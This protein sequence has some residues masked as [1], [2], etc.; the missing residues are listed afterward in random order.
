MRYLELL[1]VALIAVIPL[2]NDLKDKRE[3][4]PFFKRITFSGWSVITFSA[5]L[6]IL[7]ALRI[8][9]EIIM[10][11]T[12]QENDISSVIEISSLSKKTIDSIYKIL[13]GEIFLRGASI[14]DNS[15]DINYEKENPRSTGKGIDRNILVLSSNRIELQN[16]FLLHS[17]EVDDINGKAF[18]YK[19]PE[20]ENL[21]CM[22]NID[23][24]FSIKI[25]NGTFADYL[26]CNKFSQIK[27]DG[28]KAK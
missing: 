6:L 1:L 27:I 5:I 13:P 10:E 12:V 20:I 2:F 9:R 7:G 16:D 8:R 19:L 14:G 15:V 24:K 11:N 28:I 23:I 18:K 4:V 26:D 21:N 17:F 25:R 22:P 3:T